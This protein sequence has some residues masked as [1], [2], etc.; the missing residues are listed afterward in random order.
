MAN[1]RGIYKTIGTTICGN[2]ATSY[3]V[4]SDSNGVIYAFDP[5][6]TIPV[7]SC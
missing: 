1:F 5:L 7:I 6:S 3:L 2:F 4:K